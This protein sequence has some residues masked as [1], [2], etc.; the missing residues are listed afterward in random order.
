[1]TTNNK[2]SDA[3]PPFGLQPEAETYTTS[4]FENKRHI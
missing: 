3:H 2:S 1:M 4:A